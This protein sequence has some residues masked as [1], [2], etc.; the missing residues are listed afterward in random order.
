[1]PCLP[2]VDKYTDAQ[3][4]S[5]AWLEQMFDVAFSRRMCCSRACSVSTKPRLPSRS[6]VWPTMRP[7]M[8]RIQLLGDGEVAA[9]RPAQRSRDA[10]R[11]GIADDDVSAELAWRFEQPER[12]R[13][14]LTTSSAPAPWASGSIAAISSKQP[15]KF[16]DW[17]MTA[18]VSSISLE[19]ASSSR[20]VT[21]SGVADLDHFQVQARGRSCARFA[22]ASGCT[23]RETSRRLRFVAPLARAPASA[24]AVAPSYIEAFATAMPVSSQ[25]YD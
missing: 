25:M 12:E 11:L 18:A 22:R 17:T 2:I 3:S 10:E 24:N 6:T 21:P 13:I 4:A 7:G 16:G 8:R 15:K 23:A 14:A 20:S 1:M 9:G 5:S 19:R